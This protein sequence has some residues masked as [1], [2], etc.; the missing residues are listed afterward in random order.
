MIERL[1]EIVKWRMSFQV[2]AGRV[3]RV[4]KGWVWEKL[5]FGREYRITI[6]YLPPAERIPI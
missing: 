3:G 2:E 6:L 1:G 5:D 4:L